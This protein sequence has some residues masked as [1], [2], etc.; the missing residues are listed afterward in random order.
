MFPLPAASSN[1]KMDERIVS[2]D[3]DFVA[4][5]NET[6]DLVMSHV[7][8]HKHAYILRVRRLL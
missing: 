1:N 3:W 6:F 5:I 7:I 2:V 4:N 8:G